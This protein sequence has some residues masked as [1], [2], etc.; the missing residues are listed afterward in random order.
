MNPPRAVVAALCFYGLLARK[1]E[2]SHATGVA[3]LDAG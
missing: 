1:K 2:K 3:W